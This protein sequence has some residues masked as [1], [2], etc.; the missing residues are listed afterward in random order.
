[1][2][3]ICGVDEAGRGPVIG[4]MVMCGILIDSADEA[5]LIDLGVKD[6]KLLT[7]KQRES[8]FDEIKRIAKDCRVM[9]LSPSDIDEAI[10][11]DELNLN[12]LEAQTTARMVNEL[13]PHKV[14][15]DCP[16][17]NVYAYKEYLKTHVINKHIDLITEHGADRAYPVVSAA[18]IIA[19]VTRDR[20]IE[21]IKARIGQDFGS[22]YPSDPKTQEFVQKSYNKYDIF[23]RTWASYKN[24]IKGKQQSRLMDF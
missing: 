8:M 20:E 17:I 3:L 4:P 15:V 1:M 7:P 11:S 13:E 16:S 21:G 10:M 6:S 14:F 2:V 12:W 18:S 5:K 22:G 23:R 19:K 9:V 24:A